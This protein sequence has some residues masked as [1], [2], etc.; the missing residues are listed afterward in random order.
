MHPLSLDVINT[1]EGLDALRSEW[2]TLYEQATAGTNPF[3]R[4][5]WI[6]QWWQ[7][8]SRRAHVT[9]TRLHVLTMRDPHGRLQSVVPFFLG[10]WRIGP[11]RFRV[12]RLYGFHTTLTDIRTVLNAPG[13]EVAAAES[14][15]LALRTYRHQYDVC[16]LDGLEQ[17]DPFTQCLESR[18]IGRARHGPNL[19]AY[20]LSLP[21]S[22][23]LLRSRLTR[24]NRGSIQQGY[25]ALKRDGRSY[26][27][28]VVATSDGLSEALDE[29]FALHAARAGSGNGPPHHNY[30]AS[31]EDRSFL[32]NVVAD[33]AAQDLVRVCRLRVDGGVVASRVVLSAGPGF[34]LYHAGHDPAWDRYRVGTVLTAECIQMAIRAGGAFVHLGTGAEVSKLRW[35]PD[36]R[37]YKQLHIAAPTPTGEVL[38][39]LAWCLAATARRMRERWPQHRW[40]T[41][42]GL[43]SPV[44]P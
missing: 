10:T 26:A 38:S 7:S 42:G 19:L 18:T 25:N 32:R 16:I 5:T 2:Q 22:W 14:L 12:L 40:L 44:Q 11:L 30:Y 39:N 1:T 37:T 20:V 3:L 27:F 41:I 33:L 9:S 6:R 15:M 8:V 29:L 34:Y 43:S 17:G 36:A 31:E 21:V 4:W 23:E 13:W 24:N 35:S 28:E